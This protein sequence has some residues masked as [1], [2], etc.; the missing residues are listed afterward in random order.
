MP[1]QFVHTG[2]C[3]FCRDTIESNA[4]MESEG[5]L[6]IYNI[7][8]ILRGHSLVIPRKH[9]ESLF[10]LSGSELAEFT[11]FSKKV[12]ELLLEAFKGDG[13]DWSIQEGLSAGQSI[14][15]LHL[16]IVIRKPKDLGEESE[17]YS[18][19][20]ENEKHILDSASRP[21]MSEEEYKFY[22]DFLKNELHSKNKKSLDKE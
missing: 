20:R 1:E 16:H 12:T 21:H 5:F 15:H 8:P 13:F 14:P 19:I 10:D 11:Q 3:P 9:V 6:A 7:A 17:W 2:E 4:F 22:T 18:K